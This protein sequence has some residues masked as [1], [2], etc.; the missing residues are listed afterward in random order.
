MFSNV[1]EF[2]VVKAVVRAVSVDVVNLLPLLKVSTKM[3]C[4]NHAMLKHVDST[5][6][7]LD[8]PVSPESA[9]L[10]SVFTSAASK[11]TESGSTLGSIGLDLKYF[12]ARFAGNSDQSRLPSSSLASAIIV[13]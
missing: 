2:K 11:R 8:V 4:H 7:D 3:V 12:S 10:L 6:R 13:R 1:Q 9:S 5:A